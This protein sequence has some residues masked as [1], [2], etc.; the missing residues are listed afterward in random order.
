MAEMGIP[1]KLIRLVKATMTGTTSQIRVQATLSEPLQIH[2]GLRQGDALAFLLFNVALEKAIRDKGIQTDWHI[3]KKSVK[4]LAYADDIVLLGRKR[5][6]LEEAFLD[7][8]RAAGRNRTKYI[9]ICARTPDSSELIIDRYKLE[10]VVGFTYFGSK[11][12]KKNNVKEEV[13]GC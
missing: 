11:I 8:E 13:G 6:R 1:L 12:N 4:L 9:V 5:G 7:L 10:Q 3:F 2:N